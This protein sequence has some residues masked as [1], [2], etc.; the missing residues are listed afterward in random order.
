MGSLSSDWPPSYKH[1]FEH[2][3][4]FEY[5]FLAIVD[6]AKE[7][8]WSQGDGSYYEDIADCQQS[9]AP[10]VS[11]FDEDFHYIESFYLKY[12]RDH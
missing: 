6:A 8:S 7:R 1:F 11:L 10:I 4:K 9:P 5:I 3:G 2:G 12:L